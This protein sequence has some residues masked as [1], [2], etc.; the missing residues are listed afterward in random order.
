MWAGMFLTVTKGFFMKYQKILVGILPMLFMWCGCVDRQTAFEPVAVSPVTAVETVEKTPAKSDPGAKWRDLDLK[1]YPD[2]DTLLLDDYEQ[3]EYLASGA[4][5]RRDESWTMILTERGRK[6]MRTITLHFN[7]FYQ[8]VPEIELEIIKPDG[9]VV[10]PELQR[11]IATEQSQMASNIYDP[12]NKVLTIGIPDLA[13]GDIIHCRWGMQ[14]VRPRMKDVWCDIAL[15]QANS[16]ILHYVYEISAPADAPLQSIAVKD[17]VK[18]TLRKSQRRENNRIIYRYEA[19]NVPQILPEPDMPPA[20]LH[21]MRILTSTVPDWPSVSRWYYNLCEPRLQAVSPELKAYTHKLIR[22]KQGKAAVRALFDFVSQEIRYT[23]VTNEDSAPGYEPHDVKDTFAQKHG[24][25]RDKAALL[26]AMLREAGFDAFMVLFMAGDPK[27]PEIPNNYFNHAITGV[28]M[29]DGELVL[30]DPTD[31][32]SSDLLPSYAMDKSF[33]CATK[34]GDVLRRTPVIPPE[35]NM[36]SICSEVVIKEDFSLELKSELTFNGINDNIYRDAFSRWTPE[37]REQFVASALKQV[38]PGAELIKME[39]YP[40]DVR[41]LSQE[42][43]LV[44]ICKVADYV[45]I[46]WGAGALRVPFLSNGFGALSL[47]LD[48]RLLKTRRYPMQLFSTA[49]VDEVCRITLPPELKVEALPDY[50]NFNNNVLQIE[51]KVGV[52]NNVMQARRTVKLKQVEIPVKEYAQFRR[53]VLGMSSADTNKVIVK[54]NYNDPAAAFSGADAVLEDSR[55]TLDIESSTAYTVDCRQKIRVLNYAGV[56]DNSELSIPFVPGISEGKFISG[57]VI[58]PDGKRIEVDPASVQLMDKGD[59]SA[60]RYP[61]GKALI[62]PFP[63]VKPGSVIEYHWQ[64]KFTDSLLE[65]AYTLWRPMPVKQSVVEFK[66]PA[67]MEKDLE[68]VLPENGF[69]VV[70]QQQDDRKIVQVFSSNVPKMPDE[71]GTPPGRFFAPYV[72]ISA[73]KYQDVYQSVCRAIVAKAQE[74]REAGALARKLTAS[75]PDDA[76]KIK[77]I[78]DYVVKNIRAAGLEIDV[79]GVKYITAPDV[80]LRENY[81]NSVDRAVL[82]YAMLDAAGIKNI[83]IF[84]PSD[85][86]GLGAIYEK[87]IELPRNPF[88][89]VVLM[90]DLGENGGRCFLNDSDEYAPV[91]YSSHN[92]NFTLQQ[93]EAEREDF[94][95]MIDVDSGYL[96]TIKTSF[97]IKMLPGG[98]AEFTRSCEYYG[99]EFARRNRYFANIKPEEER[100]FWEQQFS[101]VLAGAELIEKS[102]N[103]DRYP[104]EIKMKFIVPDFWKQSG[105]YISFTLP[106][107]GLENLVRTAGK[108]TLPYWFFPRCFMLTEYAVE[109]P[110][111]WQHCELAAG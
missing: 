58:S 84:L 106:E 109:I 38:L 42:F 60:P 65:Y 85:V 66:Y 103:F 111:D 5:T 73:V 16:P 18:G 101:G 28:K 80:T 44:I 61:M 15:L 77:A 86:I 2:A 99:G 54:R 93:P 95:G 89:E 41:D 94:L 67:A 76:G 19:E 107:S 105:G 52:Q 72:G 108:R 29:P 98:S 81:G 83:R 6:D 78:R 79:L 13:I 88:D 33:L 1:K 92:L 55:I 39:V 24:V 31:E 27:D 68:V 30:M 90:V 74:S 11:S 53:G 45:D 10:K 50:K 63:G 32:N 57:A 23:G 70:K 59:A 25:C 9:S 3:V 64:V 8:K 35:K 100:Q 56:K 91:R 87:F 14:T 7:E 82:L 71:P 48:D 40:A 110:A 12:A 75:I 37:Y 49:G 69:N 17:E 34:D 22:G 51:N 62:V 21:C 47:M 96:S 102:R 104:G 43:Q 46:K 26:T 36:L 97:V 4:Y 20:Y